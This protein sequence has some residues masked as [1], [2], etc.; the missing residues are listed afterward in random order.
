MA[1][2]IVEKLVYD[3]VANTTKATAQMRSFADGVGKHARAIGIGMVAAGGIMTAAMTKAIKRA[4]DFEQAITN[5]ASVTGATGEAFDVARGKMEELAKTLGRTTVFT[6]SQ[7]ANAMYDLASKGFDVAAMSAD[8]LKPILDL[9]AATQADLTFATE[10]VTSTLRAFGMENTETIRIA[11]VFTKAI[12]SSAATVEKLSTSMSYVAPLAKTAGISLEETTAVLARLYDA[13]IDGSTAATSLRMT[14]AKLITPS[15]ELS[16]V[17]KKLGLTEADI[18][19]KTHTLAQV[20]QRMKDAGMSTADAMEL[21][22][23]RAGPTALILADFETQGSKATD[24][25][26][27]MTATLEMAGGTAKNVA[28]MQLNTLSGQMKLLASAI[29]SV[30]LPIGKT[31]IPKLTELAT[32]IAGVSQGISTW[33]GEHQR[34]S[35]LIVATLG[36]GGVMTLALG[37]ATVALAQFS[38]AFGVSGIVL[39]EFAGL[40]ALV[41]GAG[42]VGWKLSDWMDDLAEKSQAVRRALEG[43]DFAIYSI[44]GGI[45][46]LVAEI[47]D[48]LDWAA[49]IPAWVINFISRGPAATRG[50]LSPYYAFERQAPEMA[51]RGVEEIGTGAEMAMA[52]VTVNVFGEGKSTTEIAQDVVEVLTRTRQASP[53]YRG[54]TL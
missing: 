21:F 41:V 50:A 28:E 32:W 16:D 31:F 40:A 14:I 36:V 35:T 7:A 25:I 33:M 10:T 54:M 48:L 47:R 13:G 1:E 44:V 45:T 11:D 26:A 12:G 8:E 2:T 4:A 30:V 51:L 18:S 17:L 27:E 46:D 3:V 49:K 37:T 9:A 19:L 43:L 5:A 15:T 20:L 39:A 23:V 52:P 34:L 29:E 22:G 38:I 53:A 24:A 42:A 6:A